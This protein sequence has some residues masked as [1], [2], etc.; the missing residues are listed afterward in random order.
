MALKSSL[1]F[2]GF[3]FD[4]DYFITPAVAAASYY[5]L[6]EPEEIEI[7]NITLNGI[8][9]TDLLDRYIDDFIEDAINK[10]KE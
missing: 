4:F 5:N 8:D 2:R 6:Y 9:A 7:Y 10:L 3:D 1:L